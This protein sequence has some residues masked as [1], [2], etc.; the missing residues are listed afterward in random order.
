MGI[1][2]S[3]KPLFGK[4]YAE[5]ANAK[6]IVGSLELTAALV[7]VLTRGTRGSSGVVF[8]AA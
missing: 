8:L 6:R 3:R 5:V 7:P 2:W 1:Y 4:A